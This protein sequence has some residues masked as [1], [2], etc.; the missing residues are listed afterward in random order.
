MAFQTGFL[1]Q[2]ANYP[3]K[4]DRRLR[5]EDGELDANMDNLLKKVN[6]EKKRRWVDVY[7]SGRIL[8]S[9]CKIL[10]SILNT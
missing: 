3:S 10:S 5:Q 4:L 1:C 7:L 6:S 8:P 9:M 2:S